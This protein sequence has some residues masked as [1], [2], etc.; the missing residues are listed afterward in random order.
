MRLNISDL[1]ELAVAM[2]TLSNNL[3][4]GMTDRKVSSLFHL[5]FTGHAYVLYPYSP[6]PLPPP[7]HTHTIC[8]KQTGG[9][10]GS[11]KMQLSGKAPQMTTI[12]GLA[13]A[14]FPLINNWINYKGIIVI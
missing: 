4:P 7:R 9:L 6:C 11:V 12:F 10:L 8:G 13:F 5:D 1:P 2:P 14:P 3:F